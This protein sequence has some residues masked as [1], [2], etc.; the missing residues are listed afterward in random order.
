PLCYSDFTSCPDVTQALNQSNV[1]SDLAALNR[2]P[3]G[4]LRAP[5]GLPGEW[6]TRGYETGQAWPITPKPIMSA[7][8]ASA[9]RS[10][11]IF[12]REHLHPTLD[13][14]TLL[15]HSGPSLYRP[16][17]PERHRSP[18]PAHLSAD[19]EIASAWTDRHCTAYHQETAPD[20]ALSLSFRRQWP[21]WF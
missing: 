16:A 6:Q 10:G 21:A 9:S 19:H 18:C 3:R 2:V 15:H 1:P 13:P 7:E 11:I 4:G 14:L 20:R 12:A 8:T 17:C 5:S